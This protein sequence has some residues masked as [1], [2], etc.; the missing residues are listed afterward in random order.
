M[1]CS[2]AD[3]E[4]FRLIIET[5]ALLIKIKYKHT[6]NIK[7]I[8]LSLKNRR[9]LKYFYSLNLTALSFRFLIQH[10]ICLSLSLSEI[11]WYELQLEIDISLSWIILVMRKTKQ[12]FADIGIISKSN[13]KSRSKDATLEKVYTSPPKGKKKID[14]ACTKEE[15][16]T[17]ASSR[18]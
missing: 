11:F 15:K 8:I 1:G 6:Y 12:S 3:G 2:R 4:V 7:L 17:K 16:R 14:H 13:S 9:I 10:N 18:A 5:S